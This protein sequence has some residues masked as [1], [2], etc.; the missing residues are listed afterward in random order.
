MA[1]VKMPSGSSAEQH[2]ACQASVRGL[3]R[4]LPKRV[5]SVLYD[6]GHGADRARFVQT[7]ADEHGQD[8]LPWFETGLGNHGPYRC[9]AP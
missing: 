5:K 3:H 1:E 9:C 2:D 6:T 4:R 7:L 8:Q